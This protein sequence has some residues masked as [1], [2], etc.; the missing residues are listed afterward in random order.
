MDLSCYTF[1]SLWW[2]S[3]LLRL[4]LL[5]EWNIVPFLECRVQGN[6][7]WSPS[8]QC[9]Y[10][11]RRSSVFFLLES[12]GIPGSSHCVSAGYKP[13]SYPWGCRCDPWPCS[14]GQG[15]GVGVSCGVGC[16]PGSDP[17][18]LWLWLA[19]A[20]PIQPL[21]WNLLCALSGAL[22]SKKFL[23]NVGGRRRMDWE[24]GVNTCKLLCLAWMTMRSCCSAQGTMSS[25]WWWDMTEDNV[26]KKGMT[27]SLC[28]T[29]EIDRTL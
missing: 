18:W 14:V 15:S 7:A 17:I 8:L 9:L 16:R 25:H 3:C 29:V 21:A 11:G 4:L 6:W 24:S 1:L 12:K 5:T 2:V 20:T 19:A 13:H 26:R 28:W 23:K 10:P 22:K 27:G